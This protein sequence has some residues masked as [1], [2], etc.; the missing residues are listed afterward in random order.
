MSEQTPS[1]LRAELLDD[2]F[3]EADEHLLGVRQGLA[4]LEAS[5]DK[6]QAD[7]QIVESLFRNF[8]SFKGISG[9]VGLAPAEA[10]AHA[11]E[12]YLRL[13]R[14][15]KAQL[16]SKGLEVLMAAA[17]KLE[18]VVAAFRQEKPMPGYESLLAD[19]K[20][21]CENAEADSGFETGSGADECA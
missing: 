12:D 15:G 20:Q 4:D 9:I 1:G 3:A 6:A 5:V 18:Q 16:T 21:Q 11:A 10:V 2:F 7:P 13:M 8:H 17:R 19:L 14:G